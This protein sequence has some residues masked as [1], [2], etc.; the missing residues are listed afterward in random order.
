MAVRRLRKTGKRDEVAIATKG[1]HASARDS[2]EIK[3][4]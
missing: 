2:A 4:K 1:N 3:D